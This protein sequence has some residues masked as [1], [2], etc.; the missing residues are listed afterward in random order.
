MPNPDGEAH[1]RSVQGMFTR[2][3]GRY[4]L[5]NRLMTVGQDQRWRREVIRRAG[6][7]RGGRLLDLGAGTGDLAREA[8]RQAPSARV[9]AADFTLAMMLAGRRRLPQPDWCAADALR[10]PFPDETFD[11]VVS[12]FLL[13]NVSDLPQA[14]AE[15]RRVLK[16][17][18]RIVTLD[19]TP[20]RRSLLTPFIQFHL[21]TI[22]PALGRWLTGDAQAYTYL[23]DTTE[24]FLPAEVLAVRLGEAGFGQVGFR[25]LMFGTIAIHWGQ[26]A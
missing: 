25:R 26:K 3:A 6:L 11:S 13:R 2:I 17:G 18:G 4:D 14:L 7:P 24:H 10:L 22:I 16:P 21:H 9:T 1:A 8:L 23:P 19:T 15:Q 12:G 20:Q 5:I